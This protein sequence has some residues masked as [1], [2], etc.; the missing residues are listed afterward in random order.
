MPSVKQKKLKADISSKSMCIQHVHPK[1][2]GRYG[3]KHRNIILN[4]IKQK[5]KV[6][7]SKKLDA[8]HG[9]IESRKSETS[10]Y[11]EAVTLI[12]RRVKKNEHK[13][14]NDHGMIASTDK[15]KCEII[16]FFFAELF[17]KNHQQQ[18]EYQPIEIE[19]PFTKDEMIKVVMKL[20]NNKSSGPDSVIA[21]M[22]KHSPEINREMI[23]EIAQ[24]TSA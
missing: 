18:K 12:Q 3:K 6:I 8:E 20:K 17:V 1:C 21:E 9:D 13:I 11:Y 7:N 24:K 16:I 14:V 2:Y 5:L 4:E 23:A 15:K 10:K 19:L 22:I